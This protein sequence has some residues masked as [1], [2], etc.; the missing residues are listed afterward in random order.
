MKLTVVVAFAFLLTPLP[1]QCQDA[2][3]LEASPRHLEQQHAR[4]GRVVQVARSSAC[5]TR[6]EE[7]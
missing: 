4:I 6:T 2:Q 5:L 1:L 3:Q 7:D